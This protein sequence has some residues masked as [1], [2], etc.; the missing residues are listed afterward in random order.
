[1]KIKEEALRKWAENDLTM[2]QLPQGG[3]D[4]L[5]SYRATTCR[6]GGTE[7]DSALRITLHPENGD[8]RIDNVAVEIDPNDPGWKQTCIH[9]SSANPNPATLAKHSQARGMLVNDFLERDWPTDNAG[10]Y[11]TSIHLTHKLILAVS[12]V[13]YWLNNHTK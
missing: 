12:T 2:T 7:F 4:A 13:R 3:Y 5:F 6:N 10:C 9:E 1:M 11:C 8:W